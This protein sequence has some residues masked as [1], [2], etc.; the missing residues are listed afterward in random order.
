MNLCLSPIES[1]QLIET[2]ISSMSLFF[3]LSIALIQASSRN[4]CV[5]GTFYLCNTLVTKGTRDFLRNENVT[6]KLKFLQKSHS[7]S[8][9]VNVW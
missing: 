6:R 9:S 1:L 4:L 3:F 2:E 8:W 5:I 7:C